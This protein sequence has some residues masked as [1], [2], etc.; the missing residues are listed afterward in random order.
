MTVA[1]KDLANTVCTGV[2][3]EKLTLSLVMLVMFLSDVLSK[4]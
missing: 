4:G 3:N 1:V 2:N